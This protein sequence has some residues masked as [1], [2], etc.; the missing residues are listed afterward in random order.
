[1][2]RCANELVR[3]SRRAKVAADAASQPAVS[4]TPP[5]QD[6]PEPMRKNA[7]REAFIQQFPDFAQ[8]RQDN[9]G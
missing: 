3:K 5:S 2:E 9:V 8:E 6:A 1:M 7:L 4:P